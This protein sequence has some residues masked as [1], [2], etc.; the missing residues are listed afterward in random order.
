MA[1]CR[2]GQVRRLARLTGGDGAL[3]SSSSCVNM[4]S[5]SA[6]QLAK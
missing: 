4:Q 1:A 6:G 5:M 3:V 2:L